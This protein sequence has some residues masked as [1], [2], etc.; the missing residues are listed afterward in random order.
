MLIGHPRP[1]RARHEPR[2]VREERRLVTRFSMLA[3]LGAI[4]TLLACAIIDTTIR[5]LVPSR[6]LAHTIPTMEDR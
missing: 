2:Q 6:S 4:A 3:I 1:P 5:S